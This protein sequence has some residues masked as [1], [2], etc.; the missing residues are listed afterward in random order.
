MFLGLGR[1]VVD[2]V[3]VLGLAIGEEVE[4]FFL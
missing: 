4:G 1:G 3:G 2:E